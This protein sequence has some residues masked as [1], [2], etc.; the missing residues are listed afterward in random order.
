[1]SLCRPKQPQENFHLSVV[2][3]R[4]NKESCVGSV[5]K[6]ALYAGGYS[7]TKKCNALRAKWTII[8]QLMKIQRLGAGS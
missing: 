6:K 3:A 8:G 5:E 2:L 4:H 1:M 7:Y